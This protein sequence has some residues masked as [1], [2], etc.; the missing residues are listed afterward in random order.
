MVTPSKG[1]ASKEKKKE[2]QKEKKNTGSLSGEPDGLCGENKKNTNVHALTPIDL[3]RQAR[4]VLDFLNEKTG[5]AYRPVDTNLKLIMTR[6]QSGATVTQCRQV[7]AK[8]TRAWQGRVDMAPYLRPAT[9]FNATKFEE[10]LGELVLPP[11]D[12][13]QQ[14]KEEVGDDKT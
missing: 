14:T 8:K 4:Q 3:R 11:D 1:L 13:S 2:K 9:L 5:R 12:P 7:I 10:Y 6:L